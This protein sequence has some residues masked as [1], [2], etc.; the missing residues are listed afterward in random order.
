[1]IE[2]FPTWLLGQVAEDERTGNRN[3]DWRLHDEGD[4]DL[5]EVARSGG[6]LG[7]FGKQDAEHIARWDPRRVEDEC[8]AKRQIVTAHRT[9]VIGSSYWCDTCHVPSDQ[10]GSTWCTTLLLLGAPYA[11]RPGYREEWQL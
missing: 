2:D 3:D 9:E 6:W 8:R 11:D 7:K 5:A 10:P 4:L 1:M